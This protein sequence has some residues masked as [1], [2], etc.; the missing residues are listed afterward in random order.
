ML[1]TLLSPLTSRLPL[2]PRPGAAPSLP[3][4]DDTAAAED[5]ARDVLVELMRNSTERTKTAD[6]SQ[7]TIEVSPSIRLSSSALVTRL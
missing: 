7:E 4:V 2:T 3:P 6:T 5:F 1:Q